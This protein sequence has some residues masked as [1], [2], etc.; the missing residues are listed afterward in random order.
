M[1]DTLMLIGSVGI[2]AWGVG[3]LYPTANV[4]KGFEPM[5]RDNRLTITMEWM[6]EGFVLVFI[7][8]LGIFAVARDW[9]LDVPVALAA[10]LLAFA[11]LMALTRA[12]TSVLPIKPCPIVKSAVAATFIVATLI[13]RT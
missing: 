11:A 1:Q 2:I 10:M 13:E 4:V 12:R 8:G 9:P 6:T 3:H 5:S 7:G